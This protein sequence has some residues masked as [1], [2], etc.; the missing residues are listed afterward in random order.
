MEAFTANDVLK[1]ALIRDDFP[2]PDWKESEGGNGRREG[3]FVLYR[4]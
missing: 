3:G 4:L 2:T 1:T